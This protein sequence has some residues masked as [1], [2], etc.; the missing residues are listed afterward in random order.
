M[1][2]RKSAFGALGTPAIVGIVIGV[3][4]AILAIGL[5]VG[6]G[7]KGNN[8]FEDYCADTLYEKCSSMTS[9]LEIAKCGCDQ[10]YKG[11]NCCE[12]LG[13][14]GCQECDMIR[15][16]PFP[17]QALPEGEQYFTDVCLN[18][19]EQC[20]EPPYTVDGVSVTKGT[21]LCTQMRNGRNCCE[22]V[23]DGTACTTC[24]NNM[25]NFKSADGTPYTPYNALEDGGGL[26]TFGLLKY[27]TQEPPASS[28][29]ASSFPPG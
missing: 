21:C 29:A 26:K 19:I 17:T 5:G 16:V 27:Q 12:F 24:A 18:R 10:T 7:V 23:P 14:E 28:A 20:D 6:L 25:H 9:P 11:R 2:R 4:V 8:N 3:L 1:G 13:P 22:I 15:S